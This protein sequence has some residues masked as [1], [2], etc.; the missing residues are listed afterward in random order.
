MRCT[1]VGHTM[2]LAK[3]LTAVLA[4]SLGTAACTT[5]EPGDPDDP[6]DP[7]DPSDPTDPAKPL[8]ASGRYTL[9]S[10]F[11]LATN[12]PGKAGDVARAFIAATDDGN[13]P[14]K[15]IIEQAINAMPNGTFKSLMN[16]VKDFAAGYVNDYL[17][18]IA[19]DLLTTMKLVGNDLGDMSRNFGLNET[20]EVSGADGAY[21]ARR[22]VTGVHFKVDTT[23]VDYAF[24][25]FGAQPIAVDAVGIQVSE[26]GTLTIANN[27]VGLSYGKVLRIGL[28]GV[29]IPS[30]D[31][32]AANLGELLQHQIDCD[33]VGDVLQQACV[34]A[35]GFG[36]G[37]GTFRT[38]CQA[39][40]AAGANTI[41]NKIDQIDGS[42]LELGATGTAKIID[43]DGDRKLDTIQTGKWDG[44]CTYAGTPAPLANAT[45]FGQ[46]N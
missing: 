36:P 20:L 42:A 1:T 8:D 13:D 18:S 31:P 5:G 24:T 17:I 22:T 44:T 7:S 21:T 3:H 29:I 11:D 34:D 4:L 38:A 12:A 23:E 19:P 45:F 6:N 35:F 10:N 15:W 39:G 40:I 26:T 32:S 27:T 16:G 25:D 41:Y 2:S 33:V 37:S 28:D 46:R 30:V 43:K 14:A 9:R